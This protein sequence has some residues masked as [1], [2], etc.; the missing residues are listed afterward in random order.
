MFIKNFIFCSPYSF[1]EKDPSFI[2]FDTYIT[3][4][5]EEA[6]T[7]GLDDDIL[8]KFIDVIINKNLR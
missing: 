7:K 6:T 8:D 5:Q 2:E 1:L 4:L 3:V